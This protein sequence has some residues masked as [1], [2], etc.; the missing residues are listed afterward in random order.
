MRTRELE[1]WLIART[2]LIVAAR[3]MKQRGLLIMPL[4]LKGLKTSMLNLAGRV[5]RL[6][7]IAVEADETGA[8]LEGHLGDI[9]EQIG[10]HVEDIEFAANVL[11]NS[12]GGSTPL[13]PPPSVLNGQAGVGDLNQ[14]KPAPEPSVARASPPP[15]DVR[16]IR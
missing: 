3:L 7:R 10:A 6:N 1:R 8:L 5:E 12:A 2:E 13:P 16:V 4:E 15:N 14:T 9:K 11:G